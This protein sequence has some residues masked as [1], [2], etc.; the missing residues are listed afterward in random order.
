MTFLLESSAS[1]LILFISFPYRAVEAGLKYKYYSSWDHILKTLATF[2][3]VA[4]GSPLCQ[5]FM[6]KV[7]LSSPY[8]TDV[9]I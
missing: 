1:V 3:Q 6:A 8:C 4:A 5:P 7:L 9:M 2:Y